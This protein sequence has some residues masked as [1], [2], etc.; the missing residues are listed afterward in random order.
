MKPFL[1]Y[2]SIYLAAA[3]GMAAHD[4]PG[5]AVQRGKCEIVI[6]NV[7]EKLVFEVS[8]AKFTIKR[9]QE[10]PTYID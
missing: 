4:A 6:R 5:V 8:L 7:T 2:M 1:Y 3:A 9:D 10:I